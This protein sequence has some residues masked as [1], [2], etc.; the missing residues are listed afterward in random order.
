MSDVQTS[1][2]FR[3]NAARALGEASLRSAMRQ[4]ADTFG[5]RRADAFSSV[6]DL[7]TLRDRASA[8]RLQVLDRL[9]EYGEMFASR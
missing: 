2:A 9:Q 4:A 7:E 3:A 1:L 5:T 8:I 6:A